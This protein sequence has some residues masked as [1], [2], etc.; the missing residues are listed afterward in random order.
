M[1]QTLKQRFIAGCRALCAHLPPDAPLDALI[2]DPALR[3]ALGRALARHNAA[4][5][6]SSRRIARVLMVAEPPSIDR[7]EITDKGYIN[8]RAVLRNRAALVEALHAE[9]PPS[10]I[11]LP[12]ESVEEV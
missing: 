4:A 1:Q 10:D 5:G 6:G 9:P 7:G 12:V 2:A 8:Q 11:V 3:R